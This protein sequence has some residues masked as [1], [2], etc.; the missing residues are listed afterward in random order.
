MWKR[1]QRIR[2]IIKDESPSLIRKVG[3]TRIYSISYLSVSELILFVNLATLLQS[4]ED[5]TAMPGKSNSASKE[6]VNIFL[7]P[8]LAIRMDWTI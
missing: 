1:Y 5:V 6:D 2:N 3:V 7:Q 4:R 8:S